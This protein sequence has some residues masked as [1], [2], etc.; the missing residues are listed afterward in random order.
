MKN[1]LKEEINQIKYLFG[2]K[3]GLVISEQETEQTQLSDDKKEEYLI[4][5]QI[6]VD[7]NTSSDPEAKGKYDGIVKYYDD[8]LSG[9]NPEI[10]SQE[11]I[12]YIDD[13][14]ESKKGESGFIG[15]MAQKLSP[16]Y[17]SEWIRLNMKKS[18]SPQSGQTDGSMSTE[19]PV[20][21]GKEEEVSK[22]P[23]SI[24]DL[25]KREVSL[26]PQEVQTWCKTTEEKV[27]SEN[28]NFSDGLCLIGDSMDQNTAKTKRT[29]NETRNKTNFPLVSTETFEK[30]IDGK[31]YSVSYRYK[32]TA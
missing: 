32:V 21:G 15:G 23:T 20:M 25:L 29:A 7:V 14:Y 10:P 3:R 19:S 17:K 1:I 4:K 31:Y 16:E 11:V 12:S 18:S 26:S 6:A 13:T 22:S 27:K 28:P 9:G 30:E 8:L 24:I 5:R 2:Y